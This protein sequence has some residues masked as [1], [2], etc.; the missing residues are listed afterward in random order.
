MI[1]LNL[2]ELKVYINISHSKCIIKDVREEWADVIYTQ[3]HGIKMHALA[4]KVYHSNADTEYSEDEI[5][6][7]K[8]I[9]VG[10][11]TPAL[12]DAM[13]ELLDININLKNK[14]DGSDL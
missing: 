13:N 11:G 4:E 1:K 8:K 14:K 5:D 6:M 10:G 7:I 9:I 3:A 2:Q 12:I